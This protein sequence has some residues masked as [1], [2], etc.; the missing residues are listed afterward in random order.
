M[1]CRTL[2][3]RLQRLETRMMPVGEPVIIQV[4]YV[5]P[6]ASGEDGPR[7]SVPGAGGRR[8]GKA[9]LQVLNEEA[10]LSHLL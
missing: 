8:V 7:I 6:D 1:T 9:D 4:Q 5:S 10:L 3:K 2:S